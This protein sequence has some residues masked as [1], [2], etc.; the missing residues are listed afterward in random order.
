MS[1]AGS[2]RGDLQ[3][4]EVWQRLAAGRAE[5]RLVTVSHTD[6]PHHPIFLSLD[7]VGADLPAGCLALL[8]IRKKFV[9]L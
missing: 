5:T 6:Q 7:T 1:E 8:I 3:R 9:M 4:C 2:E